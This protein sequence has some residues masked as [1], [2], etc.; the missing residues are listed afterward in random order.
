MSTT[1]EPSGDDG[2]GR[3]FPLAPEVVRLLHRI[4]LIW[5]LAAVAQLELAGRAGWL[6]HRP[7]FAAYELTSRPLFVGLFVLGTVLAWRWDIVGGML[8]TFTAASMLV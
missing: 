6:D 8:A 3:R 1:G 5:A 2:G 7:G 4:S